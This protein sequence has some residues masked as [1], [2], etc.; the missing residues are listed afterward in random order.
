MF[1]FPKLIKPV[2]YWQKRAR[3]GSSPAFSLKTGL[4]NRQFDREGETK[5]TKIIS[6]ISLEGPDTYTQGPSCML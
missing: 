6:V 2:H 4:P 5:D 1:L 3:R